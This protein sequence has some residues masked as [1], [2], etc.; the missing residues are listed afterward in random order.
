MKRFRLLT[1]LALLT[2]GCA[3]APGTPAPPAEKNPAAQTYTGTVRTGIMAIGGETTG[4]LLETVATG[5]Y[6]L[7]T[8][9]N[10]ELF[11]ALEKLDGKKATVSGE[12]RPRAGVEVKERRIVIVHSVRAG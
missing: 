5:T 10:R 9:G 2:A 11:A 1:L 12:Y 7:D 6:E 4:V 8:R 3:A